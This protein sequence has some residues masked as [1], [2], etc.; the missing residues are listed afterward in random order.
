MALSLV[1]RRCLLQSTRLSI[2]HCFHQ[3]CIDTYMALQIKLL[4]EQSYTVIPTNVPNSERA[5]LL[6]FWMTP[7]RT[8]LCTCN[9]KTINLAKHLIFDCPL[10]RELMAHYV[11][12]LSPEL[13]TLL[14]SSTFSVF[15]NRIACSSEL[16]ECFNRV[17]GKFA[18]PLF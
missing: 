5:P 13:L 9:Y 1:K 11:L 3:T 10:T 16:T 14:D 8:R 15:L 2:L 17:V 6:R 4:H 18:Y 12:E 7:S